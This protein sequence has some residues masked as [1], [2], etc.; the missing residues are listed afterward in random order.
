M[1]KSRKGGQKGFMRPR[2]HLF[3]LYDIGKLGKI[4]V[5]E[6]GVSILK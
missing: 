3:I 2:P 1:D 4:L 5:S 6:R